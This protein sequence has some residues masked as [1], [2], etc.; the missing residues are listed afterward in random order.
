MIAMRPGVY[1]TALCMH[2]AATAERMLFP[3]EI[4]SGVIAFIVIVA[5][6]VVALACIVTL[7]IKYRKR[8]RVQAEKEDSRSSRTWQSKEDESHASKDDASIYTP[9]SVTEGTSIDDA[10]DTMS[11]ESTSVV[12]D[13]G[14]VHSSS[15]SKAIRSGAGRYPSSRYASSRA[16]YR[17][18]ESSSY[19]SHAGSSRTGTGK[20]RSAT[21]SHT[22]TGKGRSATESHTKTGSATESHSGTGKGTESHSGKEDELCIESISSSLSHHTGSARNESVSESHEDDMWNVQSISTS[23]RL[24]S[25]QNSSRV[26][27]KSS[28]GQ[29]TVS[30]SSH[31]KEDQSGSAETGS[32]DSDSKSESSSSSD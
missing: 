11:H 16:Y 21:E 4:I 8:K 26:E 5:F 32:P 10:H 24:H 1:Y 15:G 20:G 12:Y 31:S 18:N 2:Y 22:G 17:E 28:S 23:S 30:M 6:S 25:G 7:M 9:E 14:T 13:K 29:G 3:T 27:A 19:A